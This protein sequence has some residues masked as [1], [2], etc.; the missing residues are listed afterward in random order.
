MMNV[1]QIHE[2]NHDPKSTID[3]EV[4]NT[5]KLKSSS[6]LIYVSVFCK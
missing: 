2:V 1:L 4:L 3:N 5:F 6:S